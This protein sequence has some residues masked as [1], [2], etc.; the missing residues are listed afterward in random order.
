MDPNRELS[1]AIAQ[2]VYDLRTREGISQ[3]AL[4]ELIGTK[5]PRISIVENASGL[6]SLDLLRRIGEAFGKKLVIGYVDPE[7]SGEETE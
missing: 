5:Q 2:I 6:P 1:Y 3:G 4:A 7:E